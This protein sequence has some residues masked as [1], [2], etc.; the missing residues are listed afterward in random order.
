MSNPGIFGSVARRQERAH[1]DIDLLVDVDPDLD[2]LDLI[3]AAS[4]LEALLGRGVDL[5][6]SRSLRYPSPSS[7]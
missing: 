5:I 3:D 2:L 6:T 1:G 7:R 4:E